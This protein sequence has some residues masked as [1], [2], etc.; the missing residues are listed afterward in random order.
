MAAGEQ[1]PGAVQLDDAAT[2]IHA[3]CSN[4]KI[5]H[6]RSSPSRHGVQAMATRCSTSLRFSPF[7]RLRYF[8]VTAW[9][10]A[11]M[12]TI[13]VID[14]ASLCADD[15]RRGLQRIGVYFVRGVH[16]CADVRC[17]LILLMTVA[18]GAAG[19]LL[20]SIDQPCRA[21]GSPP[22]R[23]HQARSA[24]LPDGET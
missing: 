14:P 16:L 22:F 13:T 23:A 20:P 7:E 15:H 8:S 12:L 10:S 2:A 3:I 19:P 1:S 21:D 4:R 6:G 18:P 24:V 11:C 9:H 5:N 17:Q